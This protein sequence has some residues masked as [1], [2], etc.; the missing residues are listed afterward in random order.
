MRFGVMFANTGPFATP[1]GASALATAA[2]EMGLESIWAVEHVVVP[3]GYQS[4]YP[5]AD[6]GRMPGP[7][8]SPIPDPLIWLTYVAAVTSTIRLGTGI[9]IL[10]E[11]NPVVLAKEVATLDQLSG[12]RV[13]LGVGA[14][15]L[16]EEFDALGVPFADRGRRTDEYV[17]AMRALWSQ[18]QAAYDGRYVSFSGAISRPQPAAGKVPIVVGGH[19]EAAARRAGR[20]GDGFFPIR[21]SAEELTHLLELM[22]AEARAHGR[23]GDA[24]A[25]TNGSWSPK[26]DP[27]DRV[28]ELEDLGVERLI[29]A[30]PTSNPTRLRDA[31]EEL[32]NRIA[33]VA[34][35]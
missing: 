16:R 22:K 17:E 26:R 8:D 1:E 12:G 4:K 10:P 27:L 14:G 33:P 19:S 23:D 28:K 9:L 32:A 5:Y 6:S 11:R 34:T 24:I 7:E 21:G 35:G 25:V 15:W 20:Y 31:M 2:D 3:A 29:V 13:S 30:P 18:P